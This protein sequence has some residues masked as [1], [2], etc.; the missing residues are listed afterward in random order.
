MPVAQKLRGT[1]GNYIDT[2]PV[3]TERG[4]QE[5]LSLSLSP[6]TSLSTL[7]FSSVP[8]HCQ[9]AV[10]PGITSLQRGNGGNIPFMK[11][12]KASSNPNK[13]LSPQTVLNMT[14]NLYLFAMKTKHTLRSRHKTREKRIWGRVSV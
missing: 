6:P 10:A 12:P 14:G 3:V 7:G 4:T 9:V 13:H 11:K 5:P 8:S 2:P 1:D